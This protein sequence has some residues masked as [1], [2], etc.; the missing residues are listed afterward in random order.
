MPDSETRTLGEIGLFDGVDQAELR[1]LEKACIWRNYRRKEEVL[2]RDSLSRDVYFVVAGRLEI[3][4]YS[5]SGR[6][7]G[8]AT[9]KKGGYFGELA[10]IDGEPRSAS[11]VALEK[12]RLASISPHVFND[13][14][15]AQPEVSFRILRKL[16]SIIRAG[17]ERILD[18]TALG[19]HQRIYRELIR[20]LEPDPLAKDSWV[21]WPA[22]TQ[23]HIASR[24]S[25]TRETVTRVMSQIRAAGLIHKKGKSLYVRDKA[26]LELLAERVGVRNEG[27]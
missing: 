21:I 4:S 17:D 24:T 13:F 16:A 6:E 11:V 7:V 2:G 10:A 3:V 12:C 18:L 9:V 25:T 27:R 15:T 22:P 23:S 19:A 26:Q 1:R 5:L 20:L 8:Y 14:V